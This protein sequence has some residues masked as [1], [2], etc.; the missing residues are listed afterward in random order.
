M[1]VSGLLDT[2][3]ALGVSVE[4]TSR[5]TLALEPFSVI[6]A[7][8]L[9]ELRAHKEVLWHELQRRTLPDPFEIGK[10][11]GHCGSCRFWTYEGFGYLG[12]CSKGRWA[13]D[14]DGAEADPVWTSVHLTCKAQGGRG[15]K[16]VLSES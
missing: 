1:T 13:H 14:G 2:L 10:Q 9:A 4:A 16:A 8:L 15:W 12:L 3:E 6:P 5:G 11:E 7:E